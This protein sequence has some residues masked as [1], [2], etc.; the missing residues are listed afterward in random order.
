MAQPVAYQDT[1][2]VSP[3]Y[4][5]PEAV[6]FGAIVVKFARGLTRVESNLLRFIQRDW[7]AHN[8]ARNFRAA[9]L[10]PAI[11]RHWGFHP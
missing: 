9:M 10:T 1:N 2:S 7:A 8:L 11:L 4:F 5:T 6:A 3:K